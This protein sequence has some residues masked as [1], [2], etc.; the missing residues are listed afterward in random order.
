MLTPRTPQMFEKTQSA[1]AASL[2]DLQAELKS[3]KSL[4]VSRSTGPTAPRTYGSPATAS[5]RHEAPSPFGGKP[6]IP[7]WQLAGETSTPASGT[8]AAGSSAGSDEERARGEKAGEAAAYKVP[9]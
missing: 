5:P 7:S 9:A 8:P 1:Q 2:T 3:L 6:S 4:L